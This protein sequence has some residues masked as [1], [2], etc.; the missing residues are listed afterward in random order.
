MQLNFTITE[1]GPLFSSKIHKILTN[2]ES[3]IYGSYLIINKFLKSFRIDYVI[4]ILYFKLS[5]LYFLSNLYAE[6]FN[7]EAAHEK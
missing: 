7:F 5:R 1:Y 4:G 6:Q 3:F 2:I